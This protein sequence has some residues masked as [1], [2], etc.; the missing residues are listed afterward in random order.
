M[1]QVDNEVAYSRPPDPHL[2]DEE[3]R[4]EARA[5]EVSVVRTKQVHTCKPGACVRQGHDGHTYCRRRAPWPL[6]DEDTI[7]ADGNWAPKRMF[8]YMNTWVPAITVN[9]RCNCD[10]KLLTNGA[11][12]RHLTYYVSMYTTKKQGRSYNMSAVMANGLAY[13]F[14]ENDY[15]QELHDRQRSLLIRACN[16]LTREQEVPGPLVMSYLM[17]WGDRYMSHRYS[18]VFWV[19]FVDELENKYTEFGRR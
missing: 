9:M 11:D 19:L 10:G 1:I 6:S 5:V 14:A 12:T 18:T 8:G 15:V 13:H 4:R 2:P 7:D 16:T 3:Y 17:G